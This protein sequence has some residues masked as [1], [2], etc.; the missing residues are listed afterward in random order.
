[1]RLTQP[2]DMAFTSVLTTGGRCCASS[3]DDVP[4]GSP[5]RSPR[6]TSMDARVNPST[7]E[8]DG[9]HITD[10]GGEEFAGRG[11]NW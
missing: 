1:M 10:R 11:I 4:A 7:F 2:F 9:H 3:G 8:R 5:A 6:S